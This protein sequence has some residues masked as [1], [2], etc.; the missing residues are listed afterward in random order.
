M[1]IIGALKMASAACAID[2]VRRVSLRRNPASRPCV[3]SI[4][5]YTIAG[6]RN[7]LVLSIQL[8]R[9]LGE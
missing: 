6:V 2:H 5:E 8:A 1:R 7:G 4:E 9:L 3:C